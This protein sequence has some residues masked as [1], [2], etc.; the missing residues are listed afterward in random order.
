MGCHE[1]VRAIYLLTFDLYLSS[2]CVCAPVLLWNEQTSWGIL[3]CPTLRLSTT[4][5]LN[6]YTQS[7][8]ARCL[9]ANTKAHMDVCIPIHETKQMH[10]SFQ[11]MNNLAY[12]TISFTVVGYDTFITLIFVNIQTCQLGNIGTILCASNL[13]VG[14]MCL[15]TLY[16][17]ICWVMTLPGTTNHRGN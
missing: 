14:M 16:R 10:R 11:R 17:S 9:H 5:L 15:N 1:A 3:S 2:Q 13:R 7:T 12:N 8:H 4:T 6:T